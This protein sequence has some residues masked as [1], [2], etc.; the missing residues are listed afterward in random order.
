MDKIFVNSIVRLKQLMEL[1]NKTINIS[2]RMSNFTKKYNQLIELIKKTDGVDKIPQSLKNIEGK[3]DDI[4]LNVLKIIPNFFSDINLTM[5]KISSSESLCNSLCEQYESP[6]DDLLNLYTK[7]KEAIEKGQVLNDKSNR[8]TNL[9][10]TQLEDNYSTNYKAEAIKMLDMFNNFGVTS[11]EELKNSNGNN[12]RLDEKSKD[13]FKNLN[14]I[15]HN[16]S[17][18]EI[19]SNDINKIKEMLSKL[20]RINML[21]EEARI[22]EYNNIEKYIG[23]LAG[24]NMR[25]VREMGE[26]TYNNELGDKLDAMKAL[27]IFDTSTITE[28]DLLKIASIKKEDLDDILEDYLNQLVE[29]MNSVSPSDLL[30]EDVIKMKD[31]LTKLGQ[32]KSLD[33]ENRNK[34]YESMEELIKDLSKRKGYA[35]KLVYTNSKNN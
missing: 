22:N 5:Y 18:N 12:V 30:S 3:I 21:N 1:R 7:K 34:I 10:N 25:V 8:D 19:S 23:E 11:E 26:S 29:I 13:I 28:E 2:T 6:I 14:D 9:Y 33:D 24:R 31:T 20:G 17:P 15:I 4:K 35:K 32:I 16:L 27:G